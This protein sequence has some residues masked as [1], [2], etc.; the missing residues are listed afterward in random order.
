MADLTQSDLLDYTNQQ[1]GN[2]P[3]SRSPLPIPFPPRLLD[4]T[5]EGRSPPIDSPDGDPQ[6]QEREASIAIPPKGRTDR[7]RAW[8]QNRLGRST[9]LPSD[10][11][12]GG[13][14][15]NR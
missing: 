5:A 8:L 4:G 2:R 14:G 11:R 3:C 10:P 13:K 6:M 7:R 9:A 12:A 1:I 15:L